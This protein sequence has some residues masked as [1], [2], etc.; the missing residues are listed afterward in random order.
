VKEHVEVIRSRNAYAKV[1]VLLDW[2]AANRQNS[3]MNLFQTS[4]P[5]TCLSWDTEDMNPRLASTF[6]GVERFFPDRIIN[7]VKS[8]H[9]SLI[10]SNAHGV[11]T[12]NPG[13]TS[14]V[15]QLLNEEISK[16]LVA[17]DEV[18]ARGMVE[19]LMSTIR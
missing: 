19:R 4:D 17:G 1:A 11:L 12:I 8:A 5:F 13:D 10:F 18:H 6:R 15:K 14:R 2:D 9:P 7:L 3:F 16:S